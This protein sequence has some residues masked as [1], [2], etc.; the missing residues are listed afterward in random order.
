[1]KMFI[2]DWLWFKKKPDSYIL[3]NNQ[4]VNRFIWLCFIQQYPKQFTKID[5]SQCLDK[6]INDLII[7]PFVLLMLYRKAEGAESIE[8]I[9]AH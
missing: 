1:M 9:F 8:N 3:N 4:S 6:T 7:Y 5:Q 2:W